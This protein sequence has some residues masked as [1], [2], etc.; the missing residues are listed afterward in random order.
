MKSITVIELDMERAKR[1]K[2]QRE[3][4][5]PTYANSVG[6]WTSPE[7]EKA[8]LLSTNLLWSYALECAIRRLYMLPMREVENGGEDLPGGIQVRLAFEKN[9]HGNPYI[10][11]YH[12][13][14]QP[15]LTAFRV[16]GTDVL[17]LRHFIEPFMR[18]ALDEWRITREAHR[19]NGVDAW[20]IDSGAAERVGS[21]CA[22][23]ERMR[24]IIH[25]AM[26]V[27]TA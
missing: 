7:P 18:D 10:V 25:D 24:M 27:R 19:S 15:T 11:M 22:V 17:E 8:V 23:T 4:N 2:F 21:T 9:Y 16:P 5:H 20:L 3:N 26:R 13:K 14:W 6:D 1:L 12:M